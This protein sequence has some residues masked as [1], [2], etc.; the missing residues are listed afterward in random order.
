MCDEEA[1]GCCFGQCNMWMRDDRHSLRA[2]ISPY[3]SPSIS[4]NPDYSQ[5]ISTGASKHVYT[6]AK[7]LKR[8][9]FGA[10]CNS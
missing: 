3:Y 8:F 10:K 4:S 6:D 5:F 7:L 9:K 2:M 1:G